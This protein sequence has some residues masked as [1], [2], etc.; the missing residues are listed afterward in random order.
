MKGVTA[1]ATQQHQIRQHELPSY[2]HGRPSSLINQ[3]TGEEEAHDPRRRRE[4]GRRRRGRRGAVAAFRR[5]VPR[6][7][8][9]V[10]RLQ[11]RETGA[12]TRGLRPGGDGS[13]WVVPERRA[14]FTWGGVYCVVCR[15]SQRLSAEIVRASDEPPLRPPC[16]SAKNRHPSKRTC[17]ST[18]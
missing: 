3:R 4:E 17:L 11:K 7:G 16:P 5:G 15:E 18:T 12:W 10:E 1:P 8:R 13:A 6:P 9:V 2:A 14:Q